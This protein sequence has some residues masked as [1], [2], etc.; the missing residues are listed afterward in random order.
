MGPG[1]WDDVEIIMG[2][3]DDLVGEDAARAC[4]VALMAAVLSAGEAGIELDRLGT[5]L[6]DAYLTAGYDGAHAR[7]VQAMREAGL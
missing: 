5:L 1:G 4:A 2:C 3:L 6:G 7:V